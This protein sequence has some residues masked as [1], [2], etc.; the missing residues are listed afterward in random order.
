MNWQEY[1]EPILVQVA[2]FEFT[3]GTPHPLPLTHTLLLPPLFR[4]SEAFVNAKVIGDHILVLV[5]NLKV[6]TV[7]YLVSWKTGTVTLV[8]GLVQSYIVP[9]LGKTLKLCGLPDKSIK[10]QIERF[11]AVVINSSL[12]ALIR[13]RENSLEICK[14]KIDSPALH[15]QML[16]FLELPP[17]VSDT[18]LNLS[19]VHKKWVPTSTS[20]TRSKSF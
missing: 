11:M 4:F 19:M 20:Y 9:D 13:E 5:R 2:F 16:C 18:S 14:L 12:I 8:S 3:T 7:L 6:K 17:L 10:V 1:N 15:L